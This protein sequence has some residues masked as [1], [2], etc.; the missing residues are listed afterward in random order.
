MNCTY[1]GP[2]FK[3]SADL[4]EEYELVSNV[5]VCRIP[6]DWLGLLKTS[7]PE[8]LYFGN[9]IGLKKQ[10]AFKHPIGA[11]HVFWQIWCIC[12]MSVHNTDMWLYCTALP[13]TALL[14]TALHC[15]ALHCTALH[16]VYITFFM[17]IFAVQLSQPPDATN[18]CAIEGE[19]V[20]KEN[21]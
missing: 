15:T 20:L 10:P 11:C 6:S 5:C 7:T 9:S 8:F 17:T 2:S 1:W 3:V 13:C 21:V 12:N 19:K 4:D 18:N 16:L 14:C